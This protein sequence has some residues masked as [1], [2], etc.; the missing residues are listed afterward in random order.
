MIFWILI[1]DYFCLEEPY[2]VVFMVLLLLQT[3]Y[4]SSFGGHSLGDAVRRTLSKLGTNSVWSFYSLKGKK[5]KLSFSNLPICQVI[6]SKCAEL[7]VFNW[8][9]AVYVVMLWKYCVLCLTL[10]QKFI[11]HMLWF[12]CPKKH[13]WERTKKLKLLKWSTKLVRP[14]SMLLR[15]KVAQNT[16]WVLILISPV[17]LFPLSLVRILYF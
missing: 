17:L 8:L 11:W 10:K 7:L 3:L 4:L 12:L 9:T 1:W 14:W 16:R 2:L 13:A 5:G 6:I 15:G